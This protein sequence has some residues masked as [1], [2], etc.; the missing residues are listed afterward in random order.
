MIPFVVKAHSGRT[1]FR[2]SVAAAWILAILLGPT[3][4]HAYDFTYMETDKLY[5]TSIKEIIEKNY[6]DAMIALKLKAE[7]LGM[8]VR[9]VDIKRLRAILRN[10]AYL[11]ADCVDR[12]IRT[13][14]DSQ[15]ISVEKYVPACV[16]EGLKIA[17]QVEREAWSEWGLKLPN[18]P[19]DLTICT[20]AGYVI[21]FDKT[22][23]FLAE[24]DDRWP[25]V[26]DHYRV[27]KCIVDRLKSFQ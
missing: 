7:S 2:Y 26:T 23:D 13:K 18:I 20:L 27:K 21:G 15:K 11:Y 25:I 14:S 12:S 22:Y 9:K 10:K 5:N 3:E 6:R 17:D 16:K 4:V 24:E 8:E 1:V 19:T